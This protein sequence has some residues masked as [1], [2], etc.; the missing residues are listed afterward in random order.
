MLPADIAVAVPYRRDQLLLYVRRSRPFQDL[1]VAGDLARGR[2]ALLLN[3]LDSD[4]AHTTF[5]A[6]PRLVP[7]RFPQNRGRHQTLYLGLPAERSIRDLFLVAA[8]SSESS[9]DLA[10]AHDRD[11]ATAARLER[12]ARD[13]PRY[14]ELESRLEAG[15]SLHALVMS[16]DP[17]TRIRRATAEYRY[18]DG[19]RR[20][21]PDANL[22][23]WGASIA[24]VV[25]GGADGGAD[26]N[27]ERFD[28]IGGNAPIIDGVLL[29]IRPRSRDGRRVL[30]I[31][32]VWA[33][34][35]DS[36]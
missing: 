30:A 26:A 9:P 32:E 36:E 6:D 4:P 7:I 10:R 1:P 13:A 17:E 33:Y 23:T 24:V 21:V 20:A 22:L 16:F 18:S 34:P 25:D 28:S 5:A 35:K 3:G 12:P 14:F 29:R 15:Q 31:R 27:A 2:S 8:G 11:L 19:S